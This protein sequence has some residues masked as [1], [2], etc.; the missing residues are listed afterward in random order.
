MSRGY[1]G[2]GIEHTKTETNVGTLWRSA[3]IMGAQFIFT[4]GRR[5][6]KQ[7]SDTTKAWRHKPLYHFEDFDQFY[8][9]MPLD[10]RLVGIEIDDAAES[11]HGYC[12][13]ERCIYLLGAE[14]HGLTNRALSSCHDLI[15]I[16]GSRC[17]NVAVAGSIV[18][19]DRQCKEQA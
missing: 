17:L 19:Y 6:R 15:V 16:P 1:F 12:H 3:D 14:D 9:H 18:M 5:Y 10:C 2:I 11:L 4:I 8:K 7:A 13:H